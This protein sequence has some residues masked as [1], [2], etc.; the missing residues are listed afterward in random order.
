[1]AETT[2]FSSAVRGS[3]VWCRMAEPAAAVMIGQFLP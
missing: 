1:M 2:S 3:P